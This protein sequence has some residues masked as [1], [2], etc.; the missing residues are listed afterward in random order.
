MVRIGLKSPILFTSGA[1]PPWR[2]RVW[3][4]HH[5]EARCRSFSQQRII[6]QPTPRLASFETNQPAT[7]TQRQLLLCMTHRP[8]PA[9]TRPIGSI[10]D[11]D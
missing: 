6:A 11:L 7:T 1:R 2:Q 3:L 9:A 10:P 5:I 4:L 8:L